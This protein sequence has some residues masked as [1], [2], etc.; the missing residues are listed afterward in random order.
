M[1]HSDVDFRDSYV[2][3][4]CLLSFA[5]LALYGLAEVGEASAAPSCSEGPQLGVGQSGLEAVGTPCSDVIIATPGSEVTTL[6]GGGGN[7]VLIGGAEVKVIDGGDGEDKIFGD[8]TGESVPDPLGAEEAANT[9]V[10]PSSLSLTLRSKLRR[11]ERRTGLAGGKAHASTYEFCNGR[12]VLGPYSQELIGGAG[13]DWVYGQRGNDKI[14]GEGANDLLYGGPGDDQLRGGPGEDILGGDFG[15][16]YIDGQENGD[17]A[18]GDATNDSIND[19]GVSGTDTLSFASATAPGFNGPWEMTGFPGEAERGVYVSL[20]EATPCGYTS[21]NGPIQQGGG[22]DTIQGAAFENVIGS[23]FSDV[24]FGNKY[25]NRIDG[26]GGADAIYGRGGNDVLVGGAYGDYLQG[27]E[28]TDT[29]WGTGGTDNCSAELKYECEGEAVKVV[30]R[31]PE[32]V[33]V[34]Y[35]QTTID[36]SVHSMQLYLVGSTLHDSIKAET[37]WDY[38]TGHRWV[39]FKMQADSSSKF[40]ISSD[41]SVNNCTYYYEKEVWCQLPGAGL[42]DTLTFAGMGNDDWI[43]IYLGEFPEFVFPVLT[44]GEGG[45]SVWGSGTTEDALIDGPGTGSDFLTGVNWD[46]VLANNEGKDTIEGGPGNDLLLN[47]QACNNIAGGGDVLRGGGEKDN[48]QWAL[49]GS[50]A[51]DV[52]LNLK[53]AGIQWPGSSPSCPAGWYPTTI[54]EVEDLEGTEQGDVLVGD[55]GQNNIFGRKGNDS[56]IG[57]AGNDRL[58]G[59]GALGAEGEDKLEGNGDYDVCVKDGSDTALTCEQVE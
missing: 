45:D 6:V 27:D 49:M 57:Q 22:L 44:G 56:M 48:A 36:P 34:G 32:L 47:T 33:S 15:A 2:R 37:W 43:T 11:L 3:A 26:G 5:L 59:K 58:E 38:P 53:T 41:A 51:V 19:S 7:D 31:N 39:V 1:R 54:E 35:E 40:D 50:S 9:Y 42:L 29:D 55:S 13:E 12:C 10:A 30:N 18:R 17:L 23:P 21:C 52:S 14:W 16:D 24:I 20:E 25:A 4:F 46:D 8:A 28:G